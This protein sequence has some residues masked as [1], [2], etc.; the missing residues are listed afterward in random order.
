M[1]PFQSMLLV[2]TLAGLATGLGAVPT[3]FGARVSHRTYDAALGLAGGIMVAASVFGLIIP[4]S[5]QG[6]LS[7]VMIGVFLGGFGL[8]AGNRVIPHLHTEYH[9][10]RGHGVGEIDEGDEIDGETDGSDGESD[11]GLL[12]DRLRRAVLVGGA[13]TLHNAPEGLAMGI[14]YASGLEEVALVLAVVI[15]LQNVP[16]GFAFA[17]PVAQ[18][19]VSTPK[20]FLY[21]TLS[22]TVPQVV[23][24]VFGFALVGIAQG[25][26]PVAAGFAAGAMLAVVLREMVPSSHGHGYADAATAAFLV[27]FVLLVVVDAAVAA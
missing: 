6:A 27:G 22:G 9:R 10:R 21:T 24:S 3:L 25:I 26:F 2:T 12:D 14:A 7:A 18:S 17:I 11:D 1:N 4:G 15:A 19:G 20:V 13:I 23:G 16:D 5:E 8:L